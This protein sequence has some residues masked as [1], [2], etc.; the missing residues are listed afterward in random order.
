MNISLFVGW[1]LCHIFHFALV[2]VVNNVCD[3]KYE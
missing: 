1:S 3:P 2:K